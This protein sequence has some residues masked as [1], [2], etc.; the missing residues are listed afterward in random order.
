MRRA[1]CVAVFLLTG[2]SC[3]LPAYETSGSVLLCTDPATT[4]PFA[5]KLAG[6]HPSE[7]TAIDAVPCG[8]A[9]I[10]GNF[11]YEVVFGPT[12]RLEADFSDSFVAQVKPDGSY[13]WKH[14]ISGTER[15]ESRRLTLLPDGLAV[16][17]EYQ[18]EL[19]F[20]D[21][22]V[23]SGADLMFMN[24]FVLRLATDGSLMTHAIFDRGG[25]GEVSVRAIDSDATGRIAVGGVFTGGFSIDPVSYMS[26][27]SEDGFLVVLD[28]AN[29]SVLLDEQFGGPGVERVTSVAF[30]DDGALYA[31]GV[32]NDGDHFWKVYGRANDD[33]VHE[34][35]VTGGAEAAFVAPLSASDDLVL[36]L[37][38]GQQ[39]FDGTMN[40]SMS[41]NFAAVCF[42]PQGDVRWHVEYPD[43][44]DGIG[45]M[46]SIYGI[47]HDSAAGYLH[48]VGGLS[49][50]GPA[51]IVHQG[52]VLGTLDPREPDVPDV[53][54]VSFRLSDGIPRHRL[55]G[56]AGDQH[57]HAVFGAGDQILL[58]GDYTDTLT[59]DPQPT[60]TAEG[61]DGFVAR[62]PRP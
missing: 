7:V 40:Y 48:V 2:P 14:K 39:V 45:I 28:G 19:T 35:D 51:N 62:I 61:I 46:A 1:V 10:A 52:A 47:H 18:V 13:G 12:D 36:V 55:I 53:M 34:Y 17:G 5:K 31:A 50:T 42:T 44:L 4:T 21:I 38:G 57:A 60:L 20:D 23:S 37:R 24:G 6:E 15:Q 59:F 41:H 22:P 11:D 9:Y 49:G 33:Q 29:L 3:L 43:A 26:D 54:L 16:A 32:M 8:D 27:G 56:D 30:D 58:V 25:L